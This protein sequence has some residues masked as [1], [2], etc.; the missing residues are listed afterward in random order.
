VLIERDE[1]TTTQKRYTC[2]IG[3]MTVAIWVAVTVVTPHT[4]VK[5]ISVT[6]QF[7][8][9]ADGFDAS[10]HGVVRV[11]AVCSVT[12]DFGWMGWLGVSRLVRIVV[13]R[14]SEDHY[15]LY[16]ATPKEPI[17]ALAKEVALSLS[18]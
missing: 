5:G 15:D 14:V 8:T 13:T 1:G 18:T 12:P 2:V 9:E 10:F 6:L 16:L 11:S 3:S 7:V 17:L 4:A